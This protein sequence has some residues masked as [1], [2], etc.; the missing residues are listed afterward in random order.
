[1]AAVASRIR[2][3]AL[4]LLLATSLA[5]SLAGC[6]SLPSGGP[7]Q[8]S[9]VTQGPGGQGQHYLQII[10]KPPVSG[11][12]PK[13]IVEG[14]LAASAS[15][16][17]RQIAR[18]YLA[19][20]AEWDPGWSA[21]V[22]SDGPTV[23]V[24]AYPAK[25]PQ[26]TATV[27]I[28]GTVRA[29]LSQYG[30]Y[31]V[32]SASAPNLPV[33]YLKKVRGQWRISSAPDKL[34]LTSYLFSYDYQ[35]RNLY[36]FDP[37]MSVLVPDPVYVPLQATPVNLLNNLVHD[38]IKAPGDWLTGGATRTAFPDGTRVL[39]V[40]LTGGTAT[41]NLGVPKAKGP[42]SKAAASLLLQ[43]RE[44]MSAQLLW[45]L[46]GSGQ[47]ESAVQSVEVLL[48]GTPWSPPHTQSNPVQHRGQASYGPPSGAS[49]T[50]YYL[51]GGDLMQRDGIQAGPT[52]IADIGKGYS[53]IAVSSGPH[54][55]QYLAVLSR[56]TL[57]A[58]PI[59]RKLTRLPGSGYT[60]M[61]WDADGDLWAT[62]NDAVVVMLRSQNNSGKLGPPVH[63][64]V[65]NIDG[66]ANL[67]PF[68]AL[69]VAPDGVRVA[70][71]VNGTDINF[72]AI[73]FPQPGTRADQTTVTIKLSQFYVSQPD[74][75]T[76]TAVTWYGSDNVISLSQ[77]GQVLTEYP[78]NGG[79]STAIPSQAQIQSITASAG[80]PLIAG[81]ATGGVVTDPNVTSAWSTVLPGTAKAIAPVYPG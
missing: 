51:D 68:T 70:I 46:S 4:G 28:G 63:V 41:V 25:D 67:G 3:A 8:S 69:R 49:R 2:A 18:D 56:G 55:S 65:L 62:T 9:T 66:T 64:T 48:N 58:G 21:I 75:G 72:G 35:L 43:Q 59:G 40:T 74:I 23:N 10:P 61:S 50:F 12:S 73:V 53:Q 37:G 27:T 77:P 42:V 19:P 45:T 39:D 78:V 31:A 60:T 81:L 11:W 14:F 34:L 13:Q 71:I 17:Y 30:A 36:F 29:N 32:P 6:V 76:F 26:N 80:S 79:S 7:V 20:G 38:L 22:Y 24:P 47:G 54:G 33:F 15:F 57:S 44:Q 16:G 5:A 52:R 1:M